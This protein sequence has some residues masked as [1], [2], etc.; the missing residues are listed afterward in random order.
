MIATSVAP[1]ETVVKTGLTGLLGGT[2]ESTAMITVSEK[3]IVSPE[4]TTPVVSPPILTKPLKKTESL[5]ISPM[6]FTIVV[7]ELLVTRAPSPA[8]MMFSPRL[9]SALSEKVIV[10]SEKVASVVSPP[11][12]TR[13]L[14]KGGSLET[15]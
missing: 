14:K 1:P 11:T 15:L 7:S 6:K 13:P 8:I 10:F 9:A 4:N 2:V 3:V 5:K 12:F